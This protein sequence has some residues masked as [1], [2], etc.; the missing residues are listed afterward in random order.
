MKFTDKDTIL[1][2]IVAIVLPFAFMLGIFVILN[3]HISPGGGFSGGV[4][5]GAS[6]ILHDTAFGYERTQKFLNFKSIRT[7][8]VAALSTY[9]IL[10]AYSFIT[11]AAQIPSNIPLGR[12][13]NILSAGFILPLNICVGLIVSTSMYL[14]FALFTRG[15]I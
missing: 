7:I 15:D 4:I 2:T 11:G 8:M 6:F 14:F 10:K 5:F 13:G 12:V 1:Q 9:G 3:G